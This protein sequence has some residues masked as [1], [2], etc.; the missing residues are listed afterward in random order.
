MRNLYTIL[1]SY[2]IYLIHTYIYYVLMN[3]H[4]LFKQKK[5]FFYKFYFF[6]LFT[7]LYIVIHNIY[8]IVL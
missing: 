2:I 3:L 7:N 1:V 5:F 4:M 6:L 8:Y